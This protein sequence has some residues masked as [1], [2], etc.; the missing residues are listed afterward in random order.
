MAPCRSPRRCSLCFC[1]SYKTNLEFSSAARGHPR[2]KGWMHGSTYFVLFKFLIV[3]IIGWQ[4]QAAERTGV[5]LQKHFASNFCATCCLKTPEFTF[6]NQGKIH[7]EW[8][9]CLQGISRTVC[10]SSNSSKH[11]GHLRPLS[12][13]T[14]HKTEERCP[15]TPKHT[16]CYLKCASLLLLSAV[17]CLL[18]RN[19]DHAELLNRGFGCWGRKP[20]V[21]V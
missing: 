7:P 5:G 12:A 21:P 3:W 2:R 9:R 10:C 15:K 16:Q 13:Q 18:G 14:Q 20:L 6:P 4:F 17:T 11:T 8:K 1:R 19:D